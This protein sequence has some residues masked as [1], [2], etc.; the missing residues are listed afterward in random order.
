MSEFVKSL[1]LS[2]FE[3]SSKL[4]FANC[5]ACVQLVYIITFIVSLS[6]VKLFEENVYSGLY[7]KKGLLFLIIRLWGWQKVLRYR[8]YHK[9]NNALFHP[10]YDRV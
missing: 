3:N 1:S 5:D 7:E 8:Y 10:K 9:A 2:I 4:S 6:G